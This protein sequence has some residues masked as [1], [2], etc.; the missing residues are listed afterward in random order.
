MKEYVFLSDILL[1]R[2]TNVYK[3]P[4]RPAPGSAIHDP[5]DMFMQAAGGI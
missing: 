2:Q 4:C 5:A 1:N 3:I